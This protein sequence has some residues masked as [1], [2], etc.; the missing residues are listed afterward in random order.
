MIFIG[1]VWLDINFWEDRDGIQFFS[2][3]W[4]YKVGLLDRY[5][6]VWEVVLRGGVLVFWVQV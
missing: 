3:K 2:E 6:G 4:G 1:N 5:L